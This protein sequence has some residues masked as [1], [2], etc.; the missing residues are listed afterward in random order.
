VGERDAGTILKNVEKNNPDK[1]KIFT[2]GVGYDVNTKLLDKIAEM[3]R[4]VSD[5]IEPSED[6]EEKISSFYTKISHPVLTD[7]AI[8]FGSVHAENVY[9]KNLPDLYKGSQLT[10]LGR[11][12]R[13]RRVCIA[14]SGMVNGRKE[15]VTC[16][17]DFRKNREDFDFL[18]HLWATRKI[19]ALMDEI[20]LHGEELELKDEIIRLSQK[21]GVMS[22]YTSYLVQEE[23]LADQNVR[24]ISPG[25]IY[26]AGRSKDTGGVGGIRISAQ[27]FHID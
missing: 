2:F 10:I 6:I 14:V 9:P 23:A 19:G 15:T 12:Q 4:S 24:T 13:G 3:C 16:W 27:A 17:A 20:R 11:Y 22:P 26:P 7:L 1:I 5:Y 8:D 25:I 21:Y 18:P